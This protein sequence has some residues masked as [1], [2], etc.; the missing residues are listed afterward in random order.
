MEERVKSELWTTTEIVSI[1]VPRH[2]FGVAI[3]G[4]IV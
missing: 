2:L 4:E 3:E 1:F